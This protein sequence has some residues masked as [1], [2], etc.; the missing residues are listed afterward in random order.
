MV[1]YLLLSTHVTGAAKHVH[2]LRSLKNN[3][4]QE[5]SKF[6]SL[7]SNVFPTALSLSVSSDAVCRQLFHT[8]VFQIIR[9]FAG[10][11]SRVHEAESDALLDALLAGLCDPNNTMKLRNQ[12][13]EG[14]SES[15]SWIVKQSSKREL[16]MNT[17]ICTLIDRL[18]VMAGHPAETKRLG[19]A[20]TFSKIYR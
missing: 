12:C 9:W 6:A 5:E 19:A 11:L 16:A 14:V 20:K 15:F 10:G 1:T 17:K 3:N 8:L 4:Q 18:L 7:Y 13:A 2:T